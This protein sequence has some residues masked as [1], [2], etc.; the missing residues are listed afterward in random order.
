MSCRGR[1]QPFRA[2]LGLVV[3][4][5]RWPPVSGNGLFCCTTTP[6][7]SGLSRSAN[8]LSTVVV[9]LKIGMEQLHGI[10]GAPPAGDIGHQPLADAAPAG[11]LAAPLNA[12]AGP[13]QLFPVKEA[14][15][16]ADDPEAVLPAQ[17]GVFVAVGPQAVRSSGPSRAVAVSSLSHQRDGT[18]GAM[19]HMKK[20]PVKAGDQ[21]W[22]RWGAGQLESVGEPLLPA[23]CVA[24]DQ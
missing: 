9:G 10:A 16:G 24:G 19:G 5:Q 4:A 1:F 21:G 17:A 22:V 11:L 23:W 18:G 6:A 8:R 3:V 15:A 14:A 7:R 2:V 12:A 13:G 20:T